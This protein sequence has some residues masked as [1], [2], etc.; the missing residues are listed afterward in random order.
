[1]RARPCQWAGQN[2]P[3]LLSRLAETRRAL[4]ATRS[5]NAKRDLI[6][7]VLRDASADDV[8]IVVSLP[9]RQP[10]PA[11]YR[12]GLEDHAGSAA[13]GRAAALTVARGGSGVRRDGG[14]ER[15]GIRRGQSRR[16]HARCS[17]GR[18]TMSRACCAGWCSGELRQGAMEAAVQEGLAV[19][20]GVPVAAVRRAAMLLSSTTAAAAVLLDG[21][22]AALEAVGLQVGSG[23][24]RCSP[25]ALRILAPRSARRGCRSWWITSWTASGSRCIATAS[26]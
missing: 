11:A 24:S 25:P 15:P 9:V 21:G 7:A 1:M 20:F 2:H 3:M 22:L 14:A 6:A 8:E 26:R 13:G 19:A 5:R 23:C 10:A 12:R 4:M 17:P 18:P 16:G